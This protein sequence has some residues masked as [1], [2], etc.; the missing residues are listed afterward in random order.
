MKC[1]ICNA[2]CQIVYS[3]MVYLGKYT[4]SLYH[5][6]QCDFLQ[7][8]RVT[9]LDEAYEESIAITDTGIVSRNLDLSR[10]V[11]VLLSALNSKLGLNRFILIFLRIFCKGLLGRVFTRFN[12]KIL[13][14]GGGYGLLVRML[15]DFGIDAYWT[16]P[17]SKNLFSK[18][19]EGSLE[20]TFDCLISF[21]VLEHLLEP[22]IHF[23]SI[24]KE[25]NP[26]HYIFSTESYGD[27]IPQQNWWYFSFL[28]GQHIS[29]YNQGTF[30][31]IAKK[32]N[33]HY[34][35]INQSFH[36]FSKEK[37]NITLIKFLVE[38]SD[39]FYS[40]AKVHYDSLTWSDHN[41]MMKSLDKNTK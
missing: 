12:G 5:C 14:F 33:Y 18:G 17:Y 15:R 37:L 31:Y 10:K 13:D 34:Y 41:K 26:R 39:I 9:W 36:L 6:N 24:L 7:L 32:Y 28:T 1:R 38:R 8:D 16:D 19:F 23:Q 27:K 29:F 3:N 35:S 25:Q 40:Y 2:N 21:E 4:S 11:L 30:D 22:D 20:N